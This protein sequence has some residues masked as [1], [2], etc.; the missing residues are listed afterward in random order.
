MDLLGNKLATLEVFAPYISKIYF[1]L[2]QTPSFELIKPIGLGL[3]T[4]GAILGS[5]MLLI[6]KFRQKEPVEI[7]LDSKAE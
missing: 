5:T 6:H 4:A 3:M 1:N 7:K 2:I